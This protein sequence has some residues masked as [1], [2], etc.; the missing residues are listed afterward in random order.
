MIGDDRNRISI[1]VLT[2]K[3]SLHVG[4]TTS[5]FLVAVAAAAAALAQRK[6]EVAAAQEPSCY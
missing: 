5:P 3:R 2:E 6:P 1:R 4:A